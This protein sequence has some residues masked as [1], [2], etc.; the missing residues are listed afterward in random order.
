MPVVIQAQK[1]DSTSNLIRKF[2]KA[3]KDADIIQI[4]RDRQY[5]QKPATIRAK[6]KS[7]KRHLRKRLKTLKEMKN[8]PE[9]V[10]DTL[11]E[12]INQL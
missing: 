7:K 8:I 1:G 4:A 3:V 5:Y 11:R 2:K 10:L 12:K 6:R 9:S